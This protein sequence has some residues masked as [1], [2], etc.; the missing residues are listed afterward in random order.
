MAH[1]PAPALHPAQCPLCGHG[2]HC[3]VQAAREAGR[4]LQDAACWCMAVR[5]PASLVARVPAAARGRSCL[6]AACVA[7][8]RQ[9]DPAA[10]EGA[11][12]AGAPGEAAAGAIAAGP[13]AGGA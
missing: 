5:V 12:H 13:C 1:A 2:N 7:A 4:P 9:A 10:R 8:A 11:L 3:G 6:C